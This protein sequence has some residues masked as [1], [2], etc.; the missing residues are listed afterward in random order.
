MAAF[1]VP[2]QIIGSIQNCGDTFLLSN[3]SL[4]S[5]GKTVDNTSFKASTVDANGG[6]SF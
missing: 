3:F 4:C 6:M 1:C 5:V 2:G